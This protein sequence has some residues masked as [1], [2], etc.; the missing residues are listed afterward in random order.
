[1]EIKH[2]PDIIDFE[3][4]KELLTIL[5][6]TK[7]ESLQSLV[8][9]SEGVKVTILSSNEDGNHYVGY[10]GDSI[11]KN[12]VNITYS[13]YKVRREISDEVLRY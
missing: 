6:F 2:I 13:N 8:F 9:G 3:K 1:M 11:A 4:L 10:D 5:G 7:I 12:V